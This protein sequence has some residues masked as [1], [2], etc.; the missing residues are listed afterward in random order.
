MDDGPDV[1]ELKSRISF[2]IKFW[3]EFDNK[4]I[5]GSGWYKLLESI[6][7]NK[8]G[9]LTQAAKE[10]NYSYKYAWNILKRIETRTGKSP[11]ITGKGGKGGGGW[12]KLNVW[13][14]YLLKTYKKYSE[15]IQILTKNMNKT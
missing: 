3:L 6:E 12:V 9:S 13:G 2:R 8:I 10:C 1:E 7:N 5:M 11:V 14:K 4:S 15:Q